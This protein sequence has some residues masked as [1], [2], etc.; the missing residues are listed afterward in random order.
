[1][2]TGVLTALIE[3]EEA[4][5]PPQGTQLRQALNTWR[6]EIKKSQWANSAEIQKQFRSAD[7]VGNNRVVLNICGNKYR[8]VV[9]LNY[10]IPVAGV[11]FAGTHAEY[12]DFDDIRTV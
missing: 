1:M 3:R 2:G 8:L 6:A 5:H 9:M 4:V 11:R 10:A 7:H 12:D